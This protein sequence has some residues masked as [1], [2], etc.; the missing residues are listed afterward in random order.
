[1][2]CTQL[3]SPHTFDMSF[4][5]PL[6]LAECRSEVWHGLGSSCAA[7][8][9]GLWALQILHQGKWLLRKTWSQECCSLVL[10][11]EY[12]Q[13]NCWS[14]RWNVGIP[15][16]LR[17]VWEWKVSFESFVMLSIRFHLTNFNQISFFSEFTVRSIFQGQCS[18]SVTPSL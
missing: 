4:S 15:E 12:Y 1:M 18:L 2:R 7:C 6:R 8:S 14:R 3:N 9:F 5:V 13:H 10:H 11:N 17:Q 16:S